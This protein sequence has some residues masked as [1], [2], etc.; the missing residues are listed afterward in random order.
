MRKKRVLIT[1][2]SGFIGQFVLKEMLKDEDVHS[3]LIMVENCLANF[4]STTPKE[5][6]LPHLKNSF[7]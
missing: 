4:Y 5:T 7:P 3:L 2:A 1:G 6:F